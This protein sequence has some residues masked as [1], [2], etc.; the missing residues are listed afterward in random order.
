MSAEPLPVLVIGAG[1]EQC[2]DDAA[3]PLVARSIQSRSIPGVEVCAGDYDP[4]E[5]IDLWKSARAVIL[6]DAMSS[7]RPPGTVD[8][9][10][11]HDHPLPTGRFRHTSTHN[12]GVAEAIELARALKQLPARFVVYGIEGRSFDPGSP[13]SPEVRLTANALVD[14][15]VAAF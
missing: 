4:L 10:D 1:N 14:L 8:R 15:I 6:I 11:V 3:G 12:M 5:L 9:F 2:G 7:G 13:L